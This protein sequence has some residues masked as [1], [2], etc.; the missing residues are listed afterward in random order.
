VEFITPSEGAYAEMGGPCLIQWKVIGNG[1][2]EQKLF[3]QSCIKGW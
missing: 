1:V 3:P 2:A